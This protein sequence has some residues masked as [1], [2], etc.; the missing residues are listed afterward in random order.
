MFCSSQVYTCLLKVKP[1]EFSVVY[2]QVSMHIFVV[3]LIHYIIFKEVPLFV[4]PLQYPDMFVGK[5]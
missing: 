2:S 3:T 4:Q 1:T 5:D